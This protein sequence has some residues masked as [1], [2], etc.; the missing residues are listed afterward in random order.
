ML[1]AS[2]HPLVRHKMALLRR[3]DCGPKRFRELV[4]ELSMLLCYEAT[5]DLDL[6]PEVVETPMG[7]AQGQVLRTRVGLIPI[8]RAGLGMV[9]GALEM[10]PTAQ[11]WHIGLYRD[12]RTLRPVHYYNKLPTEPTVQLSLVLD[13][14]LATGGSA[15]ATVDL[16]KQ[17]G[18]ERIKYVG[19]LAAPEGVAR[20]STA[21][22][23]VDVHVAAVDERLNEIGYI[24]P[25]LGD[26]GDRQFGTA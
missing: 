15:V 23:E 13:P 5:R 9:D 2:D 10:I 19:L 24:V 17:W 18:S 4:R 20:L 6:V 16:L 8:L 21:H 7:T 14:M 25:G 26:A 3:V 22:P 1:Y 11:V 12:E